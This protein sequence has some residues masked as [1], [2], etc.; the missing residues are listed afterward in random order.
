MSIIKRD[1]DVSQ[2]NAVMALSILSIFVNTIAV[3]ATIYC[4]NAKMMQHTRPILTL[5]KFVGCMLLATSCIVFTGEN[6]TFNCTARIFLFNISFTFVL[7]PYI[8]KAIIFYNTLI[9]SFQTKTFHGTTMLIQIFP[10]IPF[11]AV[12]VILISFSLYVGNSRGASTIEIGDNYYCG[13]YNNDI[14]FGLLLGYKCILILVSWWFSY[15]LRHVLKVFTLIFSVDSTFRA[16]IGSAVLAVWRLGKDAPTAIVFASAGA[17]LCSFVTAFVN[18][19]PVIM[20]L[21]MGDQGAI[22][23]VVEDLFDAKKREEEVSLS[24]EVLVV[25]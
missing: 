1:I 23:D 2:Y 21:T 22:G 17:C 24:F 18:S 8:I 7:S 10:M 16:I 25:R 11:L 5:Q 9:L 13:Y 20:I 3:F 6:S 4:W 14:L 19:I 15:V 12:D